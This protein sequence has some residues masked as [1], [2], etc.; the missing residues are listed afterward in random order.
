MAN[1][2]SSSGNR[3]FS[4]GQQLQFEETLP[5]ESEDFIETR[6]S[7]FQKSFSGIENLLSESCSAIHEQSLDSLCTFVKNSYDGRGLN[8]IGGGNSSFNAT[9]P[10]ALLILGMGGVD[11]ASRLYQNIATALA[12]E[13]NNRVAYLQ[14]CINLKKV[15]TEII[16]QLIDEDFDETSGVHFSHLKLLITL[17]FCMHLECFGV[18]F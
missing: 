8:S 16:D 12:R 2:D 1:L 13:G 14:E 11:D 4:D 6:I 9:L 15:L 17:C 18:Q 10:T 7:L 5:S 3:F